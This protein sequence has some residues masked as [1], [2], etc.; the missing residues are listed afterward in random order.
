MRSPILIGLAWAATLALAFLLGSQFRPATP[1]HDDRPAAGN[2]AAAPEAPSLHT[3]EARTSSDAGGRASA[4]AAA[5]DAEAAKP[6]I[7]PGMKPA[8]FSLLFMRYAEKKLMQ[9][10]EGQKELYRELDRLTRDQGLKELVRDEQTAMP[11]VYP[12]VRF[13]VG[14]DKQVIEMMETLYKTA[15]EEPA[16][17]EG[18]DDNTFEVFTEG[19][20]F[21]LP[22][23]ADEETLARFRAYAEKIVALPGESLPDALRKNQGEIGRNLEWWAAPLSSEQIADLLRDPAQPT[24]RKLALLRRA[25]PASLR[26]V[27]VTRIVV[28]AVRG[29]DTTAIWALHGL[30]AGTIDA[31]QLDQAVLDAAG[32][33]QVEWHEIRSYLSGTDRE[34]WETMRPFVQMGLT[35]GGKTAEA[36]AQSLVFMTD[37]VPKEFVRGVLA[38][39][40]LPEEIKTQLEAAFGLR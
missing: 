17:F 2:R 32:N 22:G 1:A 3:P 21:L 10:P 15:A 11:L 38:T 6:A 23:A 30:P 7:Q 9:G 35:R 25:D 19:V 12:W 5:T 34:T 18:T 33:G 28:D 36:C 27:D 13:L 16:W 29:G 14:H 8:D 20:A 39:Y 26:G 31:T 24:A 37:E 4:P 40:A